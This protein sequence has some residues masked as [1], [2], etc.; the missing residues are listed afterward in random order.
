MKVQVK[1]QL[2]I[3]IRENGTE[4]LAQAGDR[5]IL[6]ILSIIFFFTGGYSWEGI[7]SIDQ[8]SIACYCNGT[9][10]EMNARYIRLNK[11]NFSNLNMLMK[12]GEL[13]NHPSRTRLA[14]PVF[15]L[16]YFL[17]NLIN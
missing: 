6:L 3:T 8:G 17:K 4:G 15:G 11:M 14:K 9:E 10:V 5:L 1:Q 12:R 2:T 13:I 7:K 16:V